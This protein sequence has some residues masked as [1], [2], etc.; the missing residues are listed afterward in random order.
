MDGSRLSGNVSL[1]LGDMTFTYDPDGRFDALA[2]GET[3]I[4]SFSYTVSDPLG[5]SDDAAVT[6]TI[7]GVND[8]P[9][10]GSP[11]SNQSTIEDSAFT[12]TLPAD[13]FTDVDG[14]ALTL[15]ASN[16][17]DWL[18]FDGT[19]FTGTPE[20]TDIGSVDITVI[21]TDPSGETAS[22]TFTLS[23]SGLNNV[24]TAMAD[25]YT[26]DEDTPLAIAAA[27]V[28]AN[29]AD[30]DGDALT[31]VLVSDVSNGTLSLNADGSFIYTPDENFNGA[32][33]F[34]YTPNDGTTDG[35]AVTVDITV[36][37]VNDAPTITA[38]D[39]GTV[40]EDDAVQT[41]NLLA[42]ANDAEGDTLS[43]INITVTDENGD[44]VAFTDNGDGTI[45]IDP[46]QFGD[47]LNEGDSRTVTVNYAVSDGAEETA[48]TATL[49]VSGV[50]DNTA[51][52]AVDDNITGASAP[53]PITGDIQVNTET[54]SFQLY[55]SVAALEDGG[56][57]VTWSSF[58]P[59]W[60]RPW[61]LCATL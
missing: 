40:S 41:I 56:S 42:G 21:A 38:I 61:H 37:A 34:T 6:L 47:V 5:R 4:E 1:Q 3:A 30:V 16:L 26:T 8:A 13:A 2:V 54:V 27:G 11:L 44:N 7:T 59:G 12:Y 10:A 58:K 33:S 53:V 36:N 50:D 24:P 14:D 35:A 28:L 39:A 9:M 29:D 23:V 18:N 31:A 43:V 15:R 49:V 45:S 51:P 46:D 48:N 25:S 19:T 22:Q 52:V 17:P 32:D 55:S 60:L 57:V 20:Q